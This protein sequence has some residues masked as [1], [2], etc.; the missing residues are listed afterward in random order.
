VFRQA[1]ALDLRTVRSEAIKDQDAQGEL[2]ISNPVVN[3]RVGLVGEVL[4]RVPPDVLIYSTILGGSGGTGVVQAP[5][6]NDPIPPGTARTITIFARGVKRGDFAITA[7]V[8]Y[9]PQGNIDARKSQNL[10]F[11]FKV[12]EPPTD[13]NRP[14]EELAKLLQQE[15]ARPT[16]APKSGGRFSCSF[17]PSSQSSSLAGVGDLTLFGVML[18]AMFIWSRRRR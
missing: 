16:P 5:F 12:V 10:T 4:F 18:G 2:V 3:D 14:P 9:W 1:P 13:L 11:S 17:A 7:V 15:A 6:V 8:T